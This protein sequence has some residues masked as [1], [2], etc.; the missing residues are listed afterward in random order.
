MLLKKIETQ[1]NFRKVVLVP[2]GFF[3]IAV[4]ILEIWAVN[5]LATYGQQINKLEV[6][7]STLKT[8]SQFLEA[9]IASASSLRKISADAQYL[10]F[11]NTKD[12]QYVSEL[13]LALHP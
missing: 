9:E 7:K 6:T 10:D 11:Q 2:L 12:I 1:S 5:R 3:I 4:A 13:N 8:Q